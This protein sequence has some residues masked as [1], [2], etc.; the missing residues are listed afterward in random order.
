MSEFLFSFVGA[1]RCSM[2]EMA[3][4][5]ERLDKGGHSERPEGVK[6]FSATE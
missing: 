2:D 6:R 3:Q 5:L 4:N 1:V